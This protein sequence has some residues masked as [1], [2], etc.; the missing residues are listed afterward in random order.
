M[1]IKTTISLPDDVYAQ[2]ER[3]VAEGRASSVSAYFANVARRDTARA[4][5]EELIASWDVEDRASKK[6]SAAARAEVDLAWKRGKAFFS[7]RRKSAA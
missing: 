7:R 6:E 2:A 4:S 5:L 1:T 3:A